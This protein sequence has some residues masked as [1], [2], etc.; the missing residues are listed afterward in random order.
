MSVEE[1]RKVARLYHEYGPGDIDNILTPDFVG[2]SNKPGSGFDFNREDHRRFWSSEGNQEIREILHE[3]VAEGG[4]VAIR[5][6]RTG[7]Y[8]GR[9]IQ[10]EM[11]RMI[12]FEDGRIAEIWEYSDPDQWKE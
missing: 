2:H 1:N 5:L 8:Q 9:D 3:Q 7:T 12:R 11:M 10:A 4:F 6:T